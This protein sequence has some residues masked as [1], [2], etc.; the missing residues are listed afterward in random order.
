MGEQRALAASEQGSRLVCARG[1]SE[2]ADDI[3]AAVLAV[4]IAAL[5][6]AIDAVA[7]NARGQ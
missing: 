4:Q 1:E 7:A 5:C 6:A 3:N 2:V